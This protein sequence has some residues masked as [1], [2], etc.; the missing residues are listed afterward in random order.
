MDLKIFVFSDSDYKM[1]VVAFSKKYSDCCIYIV[2][3]FNLLESFHPV[4]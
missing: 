2:K 1:M 4:I 3:H